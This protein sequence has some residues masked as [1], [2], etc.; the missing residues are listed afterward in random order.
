MKEKYKAVIIDDEPYSID[1][2]TMLL[3]RN[4]VHDI[5]I[6]GTTTESTEGIQLINQLQPDVVFLDIEMP[7]LN[8]FQ[9]LDQVQNLY[10]H[11][12]FTTAYDKYAVKA[13]RYSALDYL[14]KPINAK[15][16]DEA[17][18]KLPLK[19]KVDKEHLKMTEKN[20]QTLTAHTIPDQIILPH[21]KGYLF[22]K[23]E[24]IIYCEAMGAYTK[25]FTENKQAFIT[26][27][28]LSE[29]EELLTDSYFFRIHR[30]YIVNIKKVQEMLR[31]DGG[32]LLMSNGAKIPVARNR[33]DEFFTMI[34]R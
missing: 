23:I 32:L 33:K 21:A 19:K 24:A 16:L 25:F 26:S 34:K 15:E 18:A 27:K 1:V 30:Q 10:F 8:G 5:E 12:I 2:L 31:E 6:A 9:L 13:F 17:V 28:A 20:L 22:Q 7:R 4:D 11:L 3:T 14:M 29:V